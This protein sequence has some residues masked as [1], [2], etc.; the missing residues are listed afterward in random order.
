[1]ST[2][3]EKAPAWLVVLAFATIYLVWGSTY[4]FIQIAVQH[5]PAL[6]LGALRFIAAGLVMMA[7]CLYKKEKI[8]NITQIK[9]ASIT[10]ILMLFVGTGAVIWAEKS[11]PSSLVAVLVASQ[12]IWFVVLDKPHW[13]ENFRNAKTL[14]GIVIGFIGVF[15]LFSETAGKALASSG[16]TASVIGL[17]ILII[18]TIAWAGGSLY[19]KHKLSGSFTVTA[20]WQMMAAGLA[21]LIGSVI[22]REWNGFDWTSVPIK[23][24]LAVLYLVTMGS[25]VGFSAYVWLLSVKPATQV[26]THGYVNPV[27]AVL[28]GVFFAGEHMTR[29]QFVGLGVILTSV[30]LI[31]IAKYKKKQRP[32]VK[33]NV[34]GPI[35]TTEK[36]AV[37]KPDTSLVEG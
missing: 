23:S 20:A 28:L 10:G 4:F 24:W 14:A 13:K 7:Y 12:S 37:A 30:V 34:A 25:L 17:V 1:M 9:Y 8:F 6:I 27:V 16:S 29:L 15:L 32:A 36:K 31:N 26:S 35:F 11:L 3:N 2:T 21:F 18:G 22:N 33:S 19:S 5:M